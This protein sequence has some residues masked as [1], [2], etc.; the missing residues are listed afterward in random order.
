MNIVGTEIVGTQEECRKA[1]SKAYS[2]T[3]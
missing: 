3:E 2:C 1:A